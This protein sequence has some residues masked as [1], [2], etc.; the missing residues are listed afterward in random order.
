MLSL[1]SIFRPSR[2][3]D[4]HCDVP[5]GIYDPAQARIEAESVYNII[6]KYN[7]SS[8]DV[9]RT[10]CI[11]IKEERAELAKHHI[12]VLWSDYFKPE[13]EQ[14]FPDLLKVCWQAAKQCSE[15]KHSMDL[16]A[17]QKLLDLIDQIDEMWKATGGPQKTRLQQAA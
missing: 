9:F 11:F 10:R 16:G 7:D 5:C 2:V 15:V 3:V 17:A 13:H 4:A 8:D 12:S 14:Q 6:K 1:R